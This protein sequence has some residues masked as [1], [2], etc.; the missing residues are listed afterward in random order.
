MMVGGS[1]SDPTEP[2][3]AAWRARMR[4]IAEQREWSAVQKGAILTELLNAGKRL[5]VADVMAATGIRSL[6]N[7]YR[8][9][10][11]VEAALATVERDEDGYWY[12]TKAV[13]KQKPPA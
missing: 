11:K 12:D 4:A 10:H 13:G 8:T 2:R 3:G 1:M 6:C 7:A 9:M 5:N